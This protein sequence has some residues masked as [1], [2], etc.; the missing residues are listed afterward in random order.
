MTIAMQ[1]IYTQTVGSGGASSITFNSIPQTFT[2]LK[3]VMSARSTGTNATLLVRFNG[4]TTNTNYS[5]T[6]LYGSGTVAASARYSAPYF[7]N[8]ENSNYT[9]NTFSNGEIYIAN[10]TVS[11]F[12]QIV[13]DSVTENNATAADQWLLAGLWRNTNAITSITLSQAIDTGFTQYS[14]FT[15]YGITKG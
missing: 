13:T 15:L 1:P 10:Y 9:A 7:I 4:D 3:I 14:T 8:S 2:D 12:K 6:Q 5:M 11:N